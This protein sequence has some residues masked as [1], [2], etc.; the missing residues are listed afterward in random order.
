MSV[1]DVNGKT[2]LEVAGF[3]GRESDFCGQS[4]IYE[5]TSPIHFLSK[6]SGKY[7]LPCSGQSFLMTY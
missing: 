5:P 4:I 1:C 6:V 7:I 2:I 3:W